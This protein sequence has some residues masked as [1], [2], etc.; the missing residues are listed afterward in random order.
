MKPDTLLDSMDEI[1]PE[2]ISE[3][4]PQ[5]LRTKSHAAASGKEPMQAASDSFDD[6][7][8][9][10][11][12]PHGEK[13]YHMK[14]TI[15][16]R[17]M[18]GAVAVAACAVF[19][20]GG[21]FIANQS[22]EI[23]DAGNSMYDDG[24]STLANFLGGTGALIP[25]NDGAAGAVY[26]RDNDRFY[27]PYFYWDI[28]GGD[29]RF[30]S[31]CTKTGC[32]HLPADPD[33][34][35]FDCLQWQTA[36]RRI[37]SD[38]V[39]IFGFQRNE[40]NTACLLDSTGNSSLFF[41]VT[42]LYNYNTGET[43][44]APQGK[45]QIAR[46]NCIAKDGS[47]ELY[48]IQGFA[49]NISTGYQTFCI[50]AEM[51]LQADGSYACTD[52]YF[53]P[54]A[55]MQETAQP[56]SAAVSD[57]SCPRIIAG[58]HGSETGFYTQTLSG[59]I[60]FEEVYLDGSQPHD[61]RETTT[62][63]VIYLPAEDIP[64]DAWYVNAES[65]TL[66]YL[67]AQGA[68]HKAVFDLDNCVHPAGEGLQ[69][70]NARE[71]SDGLVS[72]ESSY[73][74]VDA[75]MHFLPVPSL[76]SILGFTKDGTRILLIGSDGSTKTLYTVDA[77]SPWV[78]GDAPA[79][80]ELF[81][82][83]PANTNFGTVCSDLFLYNNLPF[84]CA[85]GEQMLE[86]DLRKGDVRFI[87]EKAE[88]DLAPQEPEPVESNA[89]TNIY[90]GK[91]EI[92][93]HDDP[94]GM[95]LADDT[96]IYRGAMYYDWTEFSEQNHVTVLQSARLAHYFTDGITSNRFYLENCMENKIWFS[97]SFG[98]ESVFAELPPAP[99]G[100]P[101]DEKMVP[102]ISSAAVVNDGGK[103][104]TVF[105]FCGLAPGA[106]DITIG[107]LWYDE[108]AQFVC[109]QNTGF[110][111]LVPCGGC[112]T[113]ALDFDNTFDTSKTISLKLLTP[114]DENGQGAA[115][116]EI[117]PDGDKLWAEH[118]ESYSICER[119][120]YYLNQDH[121]LC[122]LDLDNRG[123]G[124]EILADDADICSFT[125]NG[126]DIYIL[127]KD[128]TTVTR[129]N[130]A[131]GEKKSAN[132]QQVLNDAGYTHQK[133]YG[134][135]SV[136]NAQVSL[137]AMDDTVNNYGPIMV[138]SYNLDNG[139]ADFAVPDAR[140]KAEIK[141]AEGDVNILGGKGVLRP[142]GKEQFEDDERFYF[143]EHKYVVWAERSGNTVPSH[144]DLTE[145]Q[146][147]NG[148]QHTILSDG[149][150]IYR[151]ECPDGKILITDG[152]HPDS[153]FAQVQMPVTESGEQIT[154]LKLAHTCLCKNLDGTKT[155]R[156]FLAAG[157]TAKHNYDPAY[158]F[159]WLWFD[160]NGKL[161]SCTE[162]Q[163][164]S[165][166]DFN[167]GNYILDYRGGMNPVPALLRLTTPDEDG[168]GGEWVDVTPADRPQDGRFAIDG[169]TVYYYDANDAF[170]KC[171]LRTGEKT[172]L[173]ANPDIDSFM[174]FGDNIYLMR[175][176]NMVLTKCNLRTNEKRTADFRKIL[177]EAGYP[178]TMEYAY[179][180]YADDEKF[181]GLFYELNSNEYTEVFY[182]FDT[183]E[184]I[185]SDTALNQ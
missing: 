101:W 151:T 146:L 65:S 113:V 127:S 40:P 83:D 124:K 135:F 85:N 92:R 164:N 77:N 26:L 21:L 149:E 53:A 39:H 175:Q 153:V 18:T 63:S 59:G 118:G 50:F 104:Y 54:A 167:Y 41:E 103:T 157:Y 137:L 117:L 24:Q 131:T 174:I 115:W 42:Q 86:I 98:N 72:E 130:P 141:Q 138:V 100:Q 37:F 147:I 80:A 69:Y 136:N 145:E 66:T 84:Q 144:S 74:E 30:H 156:L 90:G 133:A 102:T 16:Q 67:D 45:A 70:N 166:L 119:K 20:G 88:E 162:A 178:D 55:F 34:A 105:S 44:D 38:G 132:I 91:G 8:F 110:G 123:A 168:K 152:L 106:N 62:A 116:T 171:D 148:T 180:N 36:E 28:T 13:E 169:N 12:S 71:L 99:D 185:C 154:E 163:E 68:L 51:T 47:R 126:P 120:L 81:G 4:K 170:C 179:T 139:S 109:L 122:R 32:T 121:D 6:E 95:V 22:R 35:D 7:S 89:Q 176:N 17:I 5:S 160:Q 112:G 73:S 52:S 114:P 125:L 31:V 142:V 93:I 183:E 11:R 181:I 82:A 172:V 158:T 134:F 49:D 2:Y 177:R 9:V 108:N 94:F 3:A 15:I 75:L 184:I 97:D 64:Q 159:F 111:N 43:V 48:V 96:R 165:T 129:W 29:N 140:R 150:T 173:E 76:N 14:H 61:P 78:S 56:D 19:V 25:M 107:L 57:A 182:D 128:Q 155:Y 87:C 23:R 58:T 46:I 27:T 161:V 1:S 143:S 33:A 10:S 60:I 79:D